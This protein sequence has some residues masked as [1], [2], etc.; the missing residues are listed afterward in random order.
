LKKKN[1]FKLNIRHKEQ[2]QRQQKVS[3][4][5]N[6]ALIDCF[7]KGGALDPRLESYPLTITKVNISSDL[8]VANCF[9]LPFN[10]NYSIEE[11]LEALEKSRYAIRKFVTK[12]IN[13]K[14]SPEIRFY[15]DA[16]FENTTAVEELLKSKPSKND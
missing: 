3:A 7:R 2:S 6:A 8:S 12:E 5:I 13:L 9:F 11:L 1:T 10:T 4:L 15:Y 14:Y 16:G